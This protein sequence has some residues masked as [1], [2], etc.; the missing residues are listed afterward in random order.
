MMWFVPILFTGGSR[1]GKMF[2]K[3]N[4]RKN[5]LTNS[6]SNFA[7]QTKFFSSTPEQLKHNLREFL[8]FDGI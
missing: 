8:I 4:P 5:S 2:A 6:Y 3:K 1:H 7:N